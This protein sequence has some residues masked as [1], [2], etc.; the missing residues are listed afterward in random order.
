MD[1]LYGLQWCSFSLCVFSTFQGT[2]F[3]EPLREVTKEQFSQMNLR[4]YNSDNSQGVI[5]PATIC[6]GHVAGR[7]LL[8]MDHYMRESHSILLAILCDA[9]FWFFA[10]PR[11]TVLCID[12]V[13]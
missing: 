5:Y 1:K 10:D 11:N 12:F 6:Q 3:K 8:V 2:V 13:R 4:Y 9:Y 7:N